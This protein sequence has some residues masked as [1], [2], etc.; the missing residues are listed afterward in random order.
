MLQEY[1]IFAQRS[2]YIYSSKMVAVFDNPY[3]TGTKHV[4]RIFLV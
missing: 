4:G 3:N 2:L 1:N